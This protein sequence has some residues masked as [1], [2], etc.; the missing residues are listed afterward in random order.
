MK[1]KNGFKKTMAAV[2]FAALCLAQGAWAVN[3][4]M[5]PNDAVYPGSI[6]SG[7]TSDA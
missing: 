5:V 2:C 6:N 3:I 7:N 4:T 1:N